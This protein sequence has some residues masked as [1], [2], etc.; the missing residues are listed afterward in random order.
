MILDVIVQGLE[1]VLVILLYI[2]IKKRIDL[3]YKIDIELIK[4]EAINVYVI[5]D[6]DI[7]E[8]SLNYLKDIDGKV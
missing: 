6:F 3:D 4:V 7:G 1:L 5:F 8:N 2:E